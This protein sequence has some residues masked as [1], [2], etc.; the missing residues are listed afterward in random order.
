[1]YSALNKAIEKGLVA[2][3]QPVGLGGIG[4]AIAKKCIAGK[5]GAKIDLA[6]VPRENNVQRND[7]LL[8][9]ESAGRII[10]TVA[11]ENRK[12]FEKI[13]EG[14]SFGFVGKIR[15]KRLEVKGLDGAQIADVEVDALEK[16]YKETLKGY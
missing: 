3:A 11:P 16:S 4:T 15:G 10:A 5:I 9:S 2:S 1:L 14:N 8:F 12:E 7:F 6:A 13:M